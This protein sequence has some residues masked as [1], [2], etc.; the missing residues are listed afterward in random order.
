MTKSLKLP[1]LASREAPLELCVYCPKLCR[2][3]CPVADV[4]A[5]ET[6]TPWGKMSAAWMVARGDLPLD[7]A[8]AAPAWA[9][10]GC[11]ACRERCD[12]KNPVANTLYDARADFFD[13][14]P[15]AV[16]VVAE[17]QQVRETEQGVALDDLGKR[18]G[19]AVDAS[20][21]T[22]LMIG[23]AYLRQEPSTAEDALRVAAELLGPVRLVRSCCGAPLQHAGDRKG[24]HRVESQL[25]REAGGLERLVVVDPGC[26]LRA[27]ELGL[28]A[29]TLVS[30]AAKRLQ[31]LQPLE[32]GATTAGPVR[33]HDPCQL[34]RGL[35]QYDEPRAVLTRLLGRAP[36]ELSRSRGEAVCSGGGGLLPVTAPETSAAMADARLGDHVELGGGTLV[37]GCASSLRRFRT[38]A[39]ALPERGRPRVV[40]LM[41]L[42]R[43]SLS[44]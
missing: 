16:R 6:V 4:E 36:L 25:K 34:G 14:A 44:S 11:L 9:C 41:T 43:Q 23:C 27:K 12:H 32:D 30:V 29:Q 33:W 8:H 38:R 40:D 19:G 13:Q 42:I 39:A 26:A 1:L 17:R 31:S 22:G 37:T 15:A 2:A 28:P 3:A 18:V 24:Q 35:G 5:R 7:E 20:S 21:R 10:S